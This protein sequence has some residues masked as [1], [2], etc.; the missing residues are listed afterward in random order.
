LLDGIMHFR[1]HVPAG[2]GLR[3][4]EL[5]KEAKAGFLE[6]P[7]GTCVR[8]RR[9]Q[10]RELNQ[11]VLPQS[12]KKQAEGLGPDSLANRFRFAYQD[13][14]VHEAF[15]KVSEI[16]RLK[17]V[18]KRPLPTEIADGRSV[19]NDESVGVR[20]ELR[21]MLQTL[22][23]VSPPPGNVRPAQ[24]IEKPL[25]MQRRIERIEADIEHRRHFT[26]VSV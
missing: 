5:P 8:S 11:R 7:E 25:R 14:D 4:L 18:L 10:T 9:P 20:R 23:R 21:R 12:G 26:P 17:L 16:R 24:P 22:L 15:R 6:R 13:V 1:H 3:I 2:T 19:R